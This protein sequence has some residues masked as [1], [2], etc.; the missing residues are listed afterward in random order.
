MIRTNRLAYT[1]A[2][3]QKAILAYKNH[4][5]TSIAGAA[6]AFQIPYSTL[7]HRVA[8]RTTRQKAHNNT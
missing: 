5:F 6:Q 1:E 3:I 2:E 8:G 4:E 7:K